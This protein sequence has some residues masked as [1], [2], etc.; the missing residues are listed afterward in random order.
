M[1]VANVN[2]RENFKNGSK[3]KRTLLKTGLT[4]LS[5]VAIATQNLYSNNLNLKDVFKYKNLNFIQKNAVQ[6]SAF[7]GLI[8][9]LMFRLWFNSFDNKNKLKNETQNTQN[10]N[11][12]IS[13]SKP[14]AV[15][16]SMVSAVN[17]ENS[18]LNKNL[19]FKDV[20]NY[21]NLNNKQKMGVKASGLSG[22]TTLLNFTPFFIRNNGDETDVPV[23]DSKKNKT[24]KILKE[25]GFATLFGGAVAAYSLYSKNLDFKVVSQY[26]NLVPQL[27]TI[28]KS[29][30]KKGLLGALS[31]G[32]LAGMVHYNNKPVSAKQK[33]VNDESCKSW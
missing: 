10:N 17:T 25:T 30:G 24:L 14:E 7:L 31:Y 11:D 15:F 29:C 1:E 32:V 27:K 5:G 2:T 13:V 28:V 21:G 20:L 3:N 19:D 9:A 16:S 18:L 23:E 33:E 8:G 6:S 4:S 12:G 26:K 22:L